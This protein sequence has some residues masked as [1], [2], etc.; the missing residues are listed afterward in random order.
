LGET[1]ETVA[2]LEL[3]TIA[4]AHALERQLK[5]KKILEAGDRD[6]PRFSPTFVSSLIRAAPSLESFRGWL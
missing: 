4:Q 2:V 6:A 1:L 3:A 5:R